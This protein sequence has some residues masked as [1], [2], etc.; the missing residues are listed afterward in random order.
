MAPDRN[1]DWETESLEDRRAAMAAFVRERDAKWAAFDTSNPRVRINQPD[2]PA[3]TPADCPALTC[4]AEGPHCHMV[5]PKCGAVR[6]GNLYCETCR[7]WWEAGKEMI[8]WA[9]WTLEA[10]RLAALTARRLR[11]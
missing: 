10:R 7:A 2:A 4:L 1:P 5:C 6:F 9:A 8:R 3:F 11:E